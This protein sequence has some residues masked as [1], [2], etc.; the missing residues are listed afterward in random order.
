MFRMER[1][2]QL[3][4]RPARRASPPSAS[5]QTENNPSDPQRLIMRRRRRKNNLLTR[6]IVASVFAHA[7][8]LPI[9]AHYGA[10]EKLKQEFGASKV[11]IITTPPL[12]E[13]PRA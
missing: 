11:V 4:M 13:K 5:P 1:W 9:A 10:F 12:V 6:I 8:A 3:W 7:I 2:S